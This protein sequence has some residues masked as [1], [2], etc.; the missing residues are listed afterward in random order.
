[1]STQPQKSLTSSARL[2]VLS[3]LML[4]AMALSAQHLMKSRYWEY[5]Y[6]EVQVANFADIV[7]QTIPGQIKSFVAGV[8]RITADEYMHIGPT[9]KA[10]QNFVAGSFAGNTEIMSL[11]ELSVILEPTNTD[12]YAVMS[13]NLALYLNRF[14]DAIKLLHRG[15]QANK[16]APDL[17]KLYGAAAYCYGF[18][19]KPSFAAP[20]EVKKYREIAVNYLDAAIKSYLANEHRMSPYM[21]DDFANLQNYYVMQSRFLADVGRKS[22]ALAAWQKVSEARQISFLGHYFTML[23]QEEIAMPDF[24]DDLLT[25]AYQA[26]FQVSTIRPPYSVPAA[27]RFWLTDPASLYYLAI[28]ARGFG[29]PSLLAEDCH[30]HRSSELNQCGHDH[31]TAQHEHVTHDPHLQQPVQPDHVCGPG[32]EHDHHH[33]STH[34]SGAA[35]E[36]EHDPECPHCASAKSWKQAGIP[37]MIQAFLMLATTIIIRRFI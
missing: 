37:V 35:H 20:A 24:P 28:Y 29:A 26:L 8:L 27:Y 25:A 33:E 11:L 2:S 12:M 15:I 14:D 23:Q 30:E 3:A 34:A 16:N 4:L 6:P 22:E 10:K 18:A 9:K 7:L 21:H 5:Y 19:K 13:H 1:M 17:H 31:S 36:H 32:C